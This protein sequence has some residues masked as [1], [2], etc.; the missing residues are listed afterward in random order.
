MESKDLGSYMDAQDEHGCFRSPEGV[1]SHEMR[2]LALAYF[3][4]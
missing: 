1:M 2:H 3:L 4:P